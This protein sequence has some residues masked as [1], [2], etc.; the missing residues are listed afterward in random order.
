MQSPKVL[1]VDGET[2]IGT[3]KLTKDNSHLDLSFSLFFFVV[4]IINVIKFYS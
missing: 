4:N 2:K 1:C 3:Q